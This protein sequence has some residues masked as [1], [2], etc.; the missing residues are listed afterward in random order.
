MAQI[1]ESRFVRLVC[2]GAVVTLFVA[3]GAPSEKSPEDRTTS[4]PL[5]P[6]AVATVAGVA[7][8]S[9]V[10]TS[11]AA[12]SPAAATA[13]PQVA[14]E[15]PTSVSHAATT[16]RLIV[17]GRVTFT[18]GSPATGT[19]VIL[20]RTPL[21]EKLSFA[22][23]SKQVEVD[24]D[25]TYRLEIEDWP[26]CG[27]QLTRSERHVDYRLLRDEEAISHGR[28]RTGLREL[29][30]DFV[31]RKSAPVRGAVLDE[32]NQPLPNV[33]VEI[34][35][36]F[37]TSRQPGQPPPQTI[38]PAYI[39]KTDDQGRFFTDRIYE[40]PADIW[41][42]GE[43]H[44]RLSQQIVA[45]DENLILHMK[46]SGATL[47]GF[48]FLKTTGAG[49]S[50][51]TVSLN[52]GPDQRPGKALPLRN[53][54][55]VTTDESGFYRYSL[56]AAGS[57]SVSVA[58][59][60]LT[61]F[62]LDGAWTNIVSISEEQVVSNFN[63]YLYSGQTLKGKVTD[64]FS[65]EPLAGV[66]V[67][68]K[69]DPKYRAVTAE[70]GSYVITGLQPSRY[71]FC[72]EKEGYLWHS[73]S[74]W[75]F[76]YVNLPP[77]EVEVTSD[78]EMV[79]SQSVSGIVKEPSGRAVAGA[80]ISAIFTGPGREFTPTAS[81]NADGSF[82]IPA[83]SNTQLHLKVAA[84]GYPIAL[85]DEIKV[86][87]EPVRDIEVVLTPGGTVAGIVLDS[88]Q[89]P[90]EG[91]SVSGT[92]PYPRSEMFGN[93]TTDADGRFILESLPSSLRLDI[94]A[95]KQGYRRTEPFVVNLQP[96]ENRT[97]LHLVF[98][99]SH[100]IAGRVTDK[101]GQPISNA[102]VQAQV[103]AANPPSTGSANTDEEGR[104]RI[105]GLSDDPVWV[106]VNHSEYRNQQ[107][108]NVPVDRD[109]IDFVLEKKESAILVGR[110]VDWKTGAPIRDFS[111]TSRSEPRPKLD[112]ATPGQFIIVEGLFVV[113]GLVDGSYYE[114][115]VKAPG[116]LDTTEN[117]M[118]ARGKGEFVWKI[119]MGPGA[120]VIGRVVASDS[121]LPLAGVRVE[122]RAPEV[123]WN[124]RG[125][126]DG[127]MTTSDDGRF[128]FEGVVPGNR[129]LV[130][131]PDAA[132]PGIFRSFTL[133][134]ADKKD[135]GDIEMGG[136][137]S[138]KGRIVR[139]P[140]EQ[141]I[142][143][144]TIQLRGGDPRYSG[145]YSAQSDGEG[146]FG[147]AS[148]PKGD[149][150]LQ[151]PEHNIGASVQFEGNES[152][153][154]VLKLGAN[155]FKGQ[156]LYQSR[157]HPSHVSFNQPRGG[158][159]FSTATDGEGKFTADLSTGLWYVNISSRKY[160]G[161][162][163]GDRIDVTPQGVAEKIFRL[164]G[165]R[166][167]G[168]V[169]DSAD[170]PLTNVEISAVLQRDPNASPPSGFYGGMR[171]LT[172]QSSWDG[173]FT[174]VGVDAGKYIVTATKRD[175]GMARAENVEVP[176]DADSAQIVLRIGGERSGTIVSKVFDLVTGAPITNSW[177][178]I[179]S[180][181]PQR[182]VDIIKRHDAEG[183]VEIGGILPGKY[184]LYVGADGYSQTQHDV[185]LQA[186]QRLELED[187]IYRGGTLKWQIV[188]GANE[189]LRVIR[190]HL[191]PNDPN[192]V[193]KIRE[194]GTDMS[195]IYQQAN[196][197]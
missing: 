162:H 126:L 55:T 183:G 171:P 65:N 40:G 163:T 167:V 166:I 77:G 20:F 14:S 164:P 66:V 197:F 114:V 18:D 21:G 63:L 170:K 181:P 161:L 143:G 54:L 172:I 13:P 110:V 151:A 105:E 59:E 96:G 136:G 176:A 192:S 60:G 144:A 135:L 23:K 17:S 150:T 91:A 97:D 88:Q 41:A 52:S 187:A 168:R 193:E 95:F 195:G 73:E 32:N 106:F 127:A 79:R 180:P 178:R 26:I 177:A 137:G 132:S 186:D 71:A 90:V 160:P 189:P 111:V 159:F 11:H 123:P 185:E 86:R 6:V 124:T 130:F 49:V 118:V 155:V 196:L 104:Y 8:P 12:T 165:G 107:V 145:N 5:A 156:V 108:S 84:T 179:T 100:F 140:G 3:C 36:R 24:S 19:V 93:A 62:P 70:N 50:G 87:S 149:Y 61:Q 42:Q 112:P 51:A 152:K 173:A 120:A 46:S 69:E 33:S 38:L 119:E 141:P 133:N 94:S 125:I 103:P 37:E 34:S 1:A 182:D 7:T 169:V 184:V 22:S 191:T 68:S 89:C 83:Y 53:T 146:H 74:T 9:A 72:L 134:H 85:S 64:S 81:S 174:F 35:S 98:G 45:P 113:E 10:V 109:D 117:T 28:V 75:N 138:I 157:P 39:G 4:A 16:S 121:K 58:K 122:L 2:L 116:Y 30:E 29:R 194:G 147:F 188:D 82:K 31:L 48:V 99:E 76:P 102:R 175:V 139:D 154:V 153:E 131:R 47:E 67:S 27:L 43:S 25:G 57:Y 92:T 78:F 148:L 101:D 115:T 44:A 158:L 80:N 142:A 190:C 56:L 15:F 128:K 129:V